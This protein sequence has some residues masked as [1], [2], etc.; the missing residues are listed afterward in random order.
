MTGPTTRRGLIGA[1]LAGVAVGGA[2]PFVLPDHPDAKLLALCADFEALQR[3]VNG[4][5]SWQVN[6]E[7]RA[8]ASFIEDDDERDVVVTALEEQ[9]W[10]IHLQIFHQRAKTIEGMRAKVRCLLL[11]DGQMRD[12]ALDDDDESNGLGLYAVTSNLLATLLQ[13]L[14]D[15]SISDATC[16]DGPLTE[17]RS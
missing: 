1:A 12:I 6:G 9:L 4:L 5:W 10:P 3:R 13:D 17:V 16:C 11:V 2:V 14:S 7:G 8:T 15:G